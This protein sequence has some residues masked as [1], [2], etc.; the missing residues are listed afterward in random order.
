MLAYVPGE[1]VGER[2]PW[3]AWVRSDAALIQ[4]GQ[5][6]RRLHVATAAFVPAADLPWL[7]GRKW[8]PGAVIGHNDA[9]PLN[10]VWRD[11]RLVGF[12]DWESAGPA[13]PEVDLAWALVTW[14]PHLMPH[15]VEPMGFTDHHDRRRRVH[16]LLDSYGYESER[17]A[18]A[19][20]I[21]T[22]CRQHAAFIRQRA[23]SGDP[24]FT[25][26]DWFAA[27]LEESATDIEALPA[28]FWSPL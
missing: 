6:L 2:R 21:G 9:S 24:F 5:W 23:G 12:F 14:V 13:S 19:A 1:T 11:G 27:A 16:L 28:S 26:L 3:P 18:F 4:V 15:M 25:E 17:Q 10:A 22:R 7:T 20:T 8:R